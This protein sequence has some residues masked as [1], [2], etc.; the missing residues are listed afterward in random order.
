MPLNPNIAHTKN[1]DLASIV[2]LAGFVIFDIPARNNM[3]NILRMIS[4]E[5]S[6]LPAHNRGRLFRLGVVTL[7]APVTIP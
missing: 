3:K 1:P 7:L 6:F 2:A 5:V 4:T